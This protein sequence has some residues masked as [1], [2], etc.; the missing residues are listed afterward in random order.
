MFDKTGTLTVGGARLVAVET[1]PGDS[2]EMALRLAASLE[3]ASHH[4]AAEAIVAAA[5]ARGLVLAVPE[6]VRETLGSGV[7]G[8]VEGRRVRVG[9]PSLVFGTARPPE[10]AMRALRRA[11][12]RAALSVFVSVDGRAIGALLLADELRTE[13][14]RAIQALRRAGIGR[15]HAGHGRSRR[16]RRDDRRGARSRR[17]AGGSG[18]VRQGRRRGDQAAPQPDPD[19]RRRHQRCARA[20]GRR[21]RNR[22]GRARRERVLAGRRRG[23]PGR[24]LDR[25]SQAVAIARRARRIAVESIVV[26]MA[27]SGLAMLAAAF[28]FLTPVA[29]PSSRKRST[30]S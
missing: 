30:S 6:G 24:R 26:G 22:D 12:W 18:P 21:R 15:N 13:T 23:D 5:T 1:A 16:G 28:G 10:W 14:P 29:G 17:S 27:L 3:L 2:A 9:A 7:E 19:G 4:I 20:C 8:M 11:S 25:V